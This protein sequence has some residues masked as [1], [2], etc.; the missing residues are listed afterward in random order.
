MVLDFKSVLSRLSLEFECPEDVADPFAENDELAGRF[1]C[2]PFRLNSL[3]KEIDGN[4][5]GVITRA[6]FS[7]ILAVLNIRFEDQPENHVV[8]DVLDHVSS[9]HNVIEDVP[10]ELWRDFVQPFFSGG[11]TL[12]AAA[13]GGALSPD[14]SGFGLRAFQR[15]VRLLFLEVLMHPELCL[16]IADYSF[17]VIDYN[18][19]KIHRV[20]VHEGAHGGPSV[21]RR[22]SAS[23]IPGNRKNLIQQE[24]SC[25]TARRF[26]LEHKSE[27]MKVRWISLSH[28]GTDVVKDA[29]NVSSAQGLEFM[30]RLA[31]KY[32]LHPLAVESALSLHSEPVTGRMTKY[33]HK[34]YDIGDSIEGERRRRGGAGESSNGD[35]EHGDRVRGEQW[36]VSIPLFRLSRRAEASLRAYEEQLAGLTVGG[37]PQLLVGETGHHYSFGA[38][39]SQTTPLAGGGYRNDVGRSLT[40]N[41]ENESGISSS[42]F[43]EQSS[44]HQNEHLLAQSQ[45]GQ[46]N[47]SST[48]Q[49]L[50]ESDVLVDDLID[51]PRRQDSG[52]SSKS[53]R[54]AGSF[55]NKRQRVDF[56]GGGKHLT[57]KAKI[58]RSGSNPL[59][60]AAHPPP[61]PAEQSANS[62]RDDRSKEPPDA[63]FSEAGIQIEVER[64]SLGLFIAG[65]PDFDTII[66]ITTDWELTRIRGLSEDGQS[67][68][69]TGVEASARD[70][71]QQH[72]GPP[73]GLEQE[74]T[75]GVKRERASSAFDDEKLF[76][77]RAN[78]ET[79]YVGPQA[80]LRGYG[81][82]FGAASVG[83]TF[84]EYFGAHIGAGGGPPS[85]NRP[86]AVSQAQLWP[87][88]F[89]AASERTPFL[90]GHHQQPADGIKPHEQQPT[91]ED[92]VGKTAAPNLAQNANNGRD[93]MNEAFTRVPQ[94]LRKPYSTVRQG[95][96][97]WLTY[98]ILDSCVDKLL[99][100]ATAFEAQLTVTST[101]A[102]R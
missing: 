53:G 35:G 25:Q 16:E 98:S 14:K 33:S 9:L 69:P 1:D 71:D 42:S 8:E 72:P 37:E 79:A 74:A 52:L 78:S 44:L 12:G 82:S 97:N 19:E 43:L 60:R 11:T 83:Y 6:E 10:D 84:S 65:K 38:T 67:G 4:D 21:F 89:S 36:F 56:G 80:H 70:D 102:S 47:Q 32:K 94:N 63:K 88:N 5:D 22:S 59:V 57:P 30:L 28:A 48:S 73:G 96:V 100:I 46:M 81:G 87:E 76:S 90:S 2:S 92:F 64:S 50:E 26:L 29:K 49:I 23:K 68:V 15:V 39:G 24:F 55:T 18:A 101:M 61:R 66:T 99:P 58:A 91:S 7:K 93:E 41:V 45:F 13:A 86:S 17:S 27:E 3:F 54:S 95:D 75:G 62:I 20:R 40:V 77:P 31:V 51:Y 34:I 85:S